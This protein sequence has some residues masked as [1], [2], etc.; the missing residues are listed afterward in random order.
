MFM[1]IYQVISSLLFYAL[2]PV[3]YLVR[4]INRK[5]LYGW[6]EKLG[7]FKAPRFKGKVIMLHGVSVGEVIA[8]EN[9]IKKI[10]TE[11]PYYNIVVTTGTKTGQEIAKKKFG[12]FAYVTYFPFDAG[13]SV[14]RWLNEIRPDVVLIA[15][16]EIW[17]AFVH[18]C[19]IRKIPVYLINGRISDS[20]YKIY[21]F[22]TPFFKQIFKFYAGVLA[23]SKEDCKKFI[24]IGAKNA[25]VMGNLKFDIKKPESE[26]KSEHRI[27]IAGSTHK[28]EDEIILGAFKKLKK[29]FPDI[30]L[31]L[32][33][34]HITRVDAVRKLA[35][36]AGLRSQDA[37]FT[38]H[39]IIILDTLGELAKAYVTCAFAFI[40]GSFNKTGGH[41]P[42][43]C[44]VFGKPVVSGPS[45]HNFRDIY[46]IL[47][48]TS[49]GKVVHWPHELEA[50][51]EKLLGDREF[52]R[53]ACK[54][55][56]TVFDAQQGAVDVV[57]NLLRG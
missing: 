30:K 17:P 13:G 31:L 3:Y 33:P 41:N 4:V 29:K 23:Q 20:T 2:L 43:E 12:E 10:K 9:L 32:A 24:K 46:A 52:Y 26:F 6:T 38:Q 25:K 14:F 51:M 7:F 19:F 36:E 48:R 8:L 50:Y 5:Y 21:R 22:M 49:A 28:G 40:G 53:Q 1:F 55:C 27:I 56:K 54:D 39:D 45:V 47:G 11:F 57:V 15:E 35:P 44:I 37:N 42:L 16:T 18:Q 34:R